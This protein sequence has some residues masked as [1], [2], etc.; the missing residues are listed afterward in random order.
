[1][2]PA[3]PLGLAR[4]SPAGLPRLSVQPARLADPARRLVIEWTTQLPTARP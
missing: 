2:S 1:V 4:A 3:H